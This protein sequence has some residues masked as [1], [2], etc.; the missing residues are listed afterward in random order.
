MV[1]LYKGNKQSGDYTVL[2]RYENSSEIV[3]E[4]PHGGAVRITT[5]LDYNSVCQIKVYSD[6]KMLCIGDSHTFGSG[7]TETG[8]IRLKGYASVLASL[9][10]IHV[11]NAG[12]P[13][14]NVTQIAARCNSMPYYF[15]KE[16]TLKGDGSYSVI[17]T[18]QNSNI[19]SFD[20][21]SM[22]TLGL[23][24][25]V[26]KFIGRSN[27]CYIIKN[28]EIIPFVIFVNSNTNTANHTDEVRIISYHRGNDIVVDNDTPF[29]T[30]VSKDKDSDV[31]VLFQGSNG[32]T[33]GQ[34]LI[35]YNNRIYDYFKCKKVLA[36]S[37]PHYDGIGLEA[38]ENTEKLMAREYGAQYFNLRRYLITDALKDAG[39]TPTET[40]SEYIALGKCPPQLLSN[41]GVHFNETGH[42]LIAMQLYKRGKLLR[43]WE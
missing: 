4:A 11:A 9:S 12:Y 30:L 2:G 25:N 19:Y 37:Y 43:Y 28:G 5:Y 13:G 31:V 16:V 7:G 24:S 27:P 41:D 15:S 33:N 3:V 6:K 35:D 23:F 36:V 34:N 18:Y 39:L 32:K 21:N 22:V 42:S 10:K 1:I 38:L 17:G 20:K 26:G 14:D 8:P 40:D 29:Y